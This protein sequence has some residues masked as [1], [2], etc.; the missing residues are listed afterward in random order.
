MASLSLF[1]SLKSVV[2][3]TASTITT[4]ANAV[5][6]VARVGELQSQNLLAETA[7]DGHAELINKHGADVGA[8]L[9]EAMSFYG[10][11]S[12]AVGGVR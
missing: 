7:L 1:G 5:H 6:N 9:T 12:T 4:T 3:A 10:S 8:K 11:L 2:V